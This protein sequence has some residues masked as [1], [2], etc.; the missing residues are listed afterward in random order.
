MKNFIYFFFLFLFFLWPV[1]N[2][3]STISVESFRFQITLDSY[4]FLA[5]VTCSTTPKRVVMA[6][7]LMNYNLTNVTALDIMNILNGQSQKDDQLLHRNFRMGL[8]YNSGKDVSFIGIRLKNGGSSYQAIAFCF[9]NDTVVSPGFLSQKWIQPDNNGKNLMIEFT[10]LNQITKE[11]SALQINAIKTF[12]GSKFSLN[13]IFDE[14]LN[15]YN[16]ATQLYLKDDFIII[17]FCCFKLKSYIWRNFY[18][19]GTTDFS[20][21]DIQKLFEASDLLK[22]FNTLINDKTNNNI[23]AIKVSVID[24]VKPS[25][26]LKIFKTL[27][28]NE[29]VTLNVS[30]NRNLYMYIVGDLIKVD[31][32][33]DSMTTENILNGTNAKGLKLAIFKT[34]E[35]QPNSVYSLDI[36]TN[37]FNSSFWFKAIGVSYGIEAERQITD[38]YNMSAISGD[39]VNIGDKQELILI[40]IVIFLSLMILN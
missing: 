29:S 7:G 37:Y 35:I 11:Y 19:P 8:P 1:E 26:N 13:T 18:A 33:S 10:Y 6:I 4:D 36:K 14:E 21:I 34:L 39:K 2:A 25:L 32:D 3:P 17:D 27:E 31:S 23:M 24:N 15:Q 22:K 12:L 9:L 20:S 30:S 28:S 5:I 40:F 16:K 38:I